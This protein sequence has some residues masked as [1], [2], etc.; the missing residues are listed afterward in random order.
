M[1]LS[2]PKAS[3]PLVPTMSVELMAGK[4]IKGRKRHIVV[5][6]H[7]HLL[8][9]TVHAANLH[10]TA[11]GIFP[12]QYAATLYPSVKR[13]CGDSGYR[14]TFVTEVEEWNGLP[15]DIVERKKEASWHVLPKRWI[16][17]RTFAWLNGSR[18]LSKDYEITTSSAESMVML[19]HIHTLL[20]RL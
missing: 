2:I 6:T 20:K 5:D 9:V 17:E 13:L 8:G 18:R 12:V 4:K 16:V 10:D 7:G 15:V 14:G 19:S 11:S 3:R 1:R